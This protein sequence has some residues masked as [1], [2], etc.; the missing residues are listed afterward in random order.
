MVI[1]VD[2]QNEFECE[3]ET[4]KASEPEPRSVICAEP[5]NDKTEDDKTEDDNVTVDSGYEE[6][7]SKILS[8]YIRNRHT[9]YTEI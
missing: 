5:E 3:P 2:K 1:F 4:K 6:V 7:G 9:L 8:R